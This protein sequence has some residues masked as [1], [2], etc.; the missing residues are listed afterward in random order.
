VQHYEARQPLPRSPFCWAD[1]RL[2]T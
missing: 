2:E 1:K